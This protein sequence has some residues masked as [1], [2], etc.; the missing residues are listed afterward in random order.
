MT[1]DQNELLAVLDVR[2]HD[3][4]AL[5]EEQKR[6]I[7]A[8]NQKI[9][10]D[11]EKLRQAEQKIQAM[12]AKYTELL[13]AHIVSLDEGDVKNARMRLLKLVREVEKCIALLNG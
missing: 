12:N 11:S 13:T 5:C 9:N 6:T 10:A 4:M 3:L 7:E 8:L 2:L 1:D